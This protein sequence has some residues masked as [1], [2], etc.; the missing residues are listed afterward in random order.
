MT[1]EF[2][3]FVVMLGLAKETGC[4]A[5][6]ESVMIRGTDTLPNKPSHIPREEHFCCVFLETNIENNKNTQRELIKT[7]CKYKRLWSTKNL[8]YLFNQ[9]NSRAE[10]STQ[11][12]S[13]VDCCVIYIPL[14]L[15]AYAWLSFASG[16]TGA[17]A[18]HPL[19]WCGE[20][21]PSRQRLQVD[22]QQLQPLMCLKLAAHCWSCL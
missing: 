2:H 1:L 5:L 16:G 13:P 7:G 15:R 6:D 10:L 17:V 19:C 14:L 9:P 11:A 3:G 18:R 4:S 12:P 20:W 22:L 8:L 21:P